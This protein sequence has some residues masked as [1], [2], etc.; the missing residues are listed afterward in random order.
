MTGTSLTPAPRHGAFVLLHLAVALLATLA[1]VPAPSAMAASFV[2]SAAALGANDSL[3]WGQL[4]AS[5]THVS[6]PVNVSSAA[7]LGITVSQ[8]TGAGSAS[9]AGPSFGPMY[10]PG[11]R[12]YWT[13]GGAPL[14]FVFAQDIYGFGAVFD[15]NNYLN[16]F[17]GTISAYDAI[18]TSLGTFPFSVSAQA[19]YKQVFAGIASTTANIHRVV[20]NG[21]YA[22][23]GPEDFFVGTAQIKTAPAQTPVAT[24]L[25]LTSTPNPSTANQSVAFTA[26]VTQLSAES[27]PNVSIAA[28]SPSATPSGSVTFADGATTLAT[29]ALDGSGI[30]SYS[31]TA[32]SV[33]THTI[34]ATFSGNGSATGSVTQQVNAQVG[35]PAVAVPAPALSPLMQSLLA[36]IL[37]GF[38]VLA[39]R[40]RHR[41]V[42]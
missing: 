40:M 10:A 41:K 29:I 16:G 21:T 18:G 8:A 42:R 39:M 17:S 33:G 30:A 38:A 25:S 12:L 19:A 32:L 31:T 22:S 20:I 26:T 24:T 28:S 6:N 35:P 13:L 7:G 2:S 23:Y 3:T 11:E 36:S 34:N 37:A 14:T 9:A 5:G 4:G 1:I 15:P 27:V